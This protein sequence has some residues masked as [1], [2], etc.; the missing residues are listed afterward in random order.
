[1]P[2]GRSIGSSASVRINAQKIG[3][4]RR[5]KSAGR[6]SESEGAAW[7]LQI[8]TWPVRRRVRFSGPQ[9]QSGSVKRTLRDYALEKR[10]WQMIKETFKEWIEDK[11][12]RLSAALAFYTMLSLAPLLI[13]ILKIVTFV[14]RK[15]GADEQIANYIGSISSPQTADTVRAIFQKEAEQPHTGT[16]A[17]IVS[18][19]I[20]LFSASGVFGE[21]QTSMNEVWELQ[22]RPNRGFMAT[23]KD[24]F[25]SITL[26]LGAAFLLLVS[27]VISTALTT[28]SKN[29]M[30]SQN[31]FWQAINLVVSIAVISVI[32]ALIFK[33]LPDAV[34]EW[35]YVWIG[36]VT[37]AV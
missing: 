24:R 8:F 18:L 27:L 31:I 11:A 23:I 26:V 22:P 16:V 36:A 5:K 34:V 10:M 35:K 28:M 21:L 15:K 12:P 6:L 29:L 32:F 14:V 2:P 3:E 25:F 13:I 1:M 30:P 37:T 4:K 17:T 19:L 9:G 20:L 33:Y 7:G